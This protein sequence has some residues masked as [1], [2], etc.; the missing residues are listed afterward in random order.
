MRDSNALSGGDAATGFA[1]GA[2]RSTFPRTSLIFIDP[3]ARDASALILG[4]GP[5]SELIFLSAVRDG[6]AQVAD[7]LSRRGRLHL[8]HLMADLSRGR[9]RLGNRHLDTRSLREHAPTL[10]RIGRSVRGGEIVIGA[11]RE[12][13]G[14]GDVFRRAFEAYAAVPVR[15]CDSGAMLRS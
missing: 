9:L 6:L 10:A 2:S 11:G 8:I 12:R 14:Q 5:K 1:S 3:S 4:A 15:L 7:H 13:E